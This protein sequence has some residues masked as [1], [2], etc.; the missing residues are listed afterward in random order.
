[1][2][3]RAI[4]RGQGEVFGVRFLGAVP[5]A[6]MRTLRWVALASECVHTSQQ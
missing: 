5:G 6:R 3:M 4:V 1:M 2:V